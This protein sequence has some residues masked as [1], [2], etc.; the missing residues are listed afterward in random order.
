[1]KVTGSE[2]KHGYVVS[3]LH[4]FAKWSSAEK[5]MSDIRK[6]C[7]DAG[8]FV[9]NGDIFD[10]RWS[11]LGSSRK[12]VELAIEWF[13]ELCTEFPECRF[14]YVLGNHDSH[15]NFLEPL[16]KLADEKENFYWHS[17]HFK[18]ASSLFMHGDLIFTMRNISPFVRKKFKNAE[19]RPAVISSGYHFAIGMG[20]HH[21]VSRI[22]AK[23][24]CAKYVLRVL[25]KKDRAKLENITDI[26]IGHTHVAFSDFAYKGFMFHNSGSAVHDLHCNIMKV[27]GGGVL[28]KH[29]D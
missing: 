9:F 5:Y 28:V 12:T 24:R 26:Y 3:D 18:I 2:M 10:F 15:V 13:R 20:A 19:P 8:F 27:D 22:Y 29:Y 14:F 23:Q 11:T 6:A 21:F 4:I 17:S 16:T 7:A 25:K 1:M